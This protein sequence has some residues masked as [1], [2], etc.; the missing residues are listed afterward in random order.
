MNPK[1]GD[2]VRIKQTGE[3]GLIVNLFP[4]ARYPFLINTQSIGNNMYM[5]REFQFA[6]NEEAMLYK[7][8]NA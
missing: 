1:I 3:V 7:L 4:K 6:T 8:E 2:F 5:E